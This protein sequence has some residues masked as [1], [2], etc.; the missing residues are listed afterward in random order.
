MSRRQEWQ[1]GYNIGTEWAV[2]TRSKKE[3]GQVLRERIRLLS[4]LV[5]RK[6]ATYTPEWA[7]TVDEAFTLYT[8]TSTVNLLQ[9]VNVLLIDLDWPFPAYLDLRTEFDRIH[10]NF[11]SIERG[12]LGT[13]E[14]LFHGPS[15]AL[16][17]LGIS[18]ANLRGKIEL[19][20]T[21]EERERAN[22]AMTQFFRMHQDEIFNDL[23][24]ARV[25]QSSR[26]ILKDIERAYEK[27]MWAACITTTVPLLDSVVRAFFHTD[28]INVT[29]QTLRDAF[30]HE[31][32]LQP[33]DLMP[34]YAVWD[35][36]RDAA[37]GNTLAKSVE[38]DLRLP[39]IYL[40]SFFEFAGRYYQWYASGN[41]CQ[42]GTLN[43]HAIMHGAFDHWTEP[44]AVRMLTFLDLTIR[45][46][47]ALRLLMHGRDAIPRRE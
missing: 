8:R 18:I 19:R 17:V 32:R 1:S 15:F 22:R 35:G 44:N 30:F 25:L 39:G 14:V 10:K 38:E 20:N 33:K 26:L 37:T 7:T 2:V 6:P 31:A 12:W 11:R 13:I 27:E 16:T 3:L 24:K 34:G 5:A 23:Q 28:R 43:R 9:S 36:A 21:L 45:L 29:I 47:P 42:D 46:E 40:S 41:S 4:N